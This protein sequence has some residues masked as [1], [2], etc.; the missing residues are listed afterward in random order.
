MAGK[1]N[2]PHPSRGR[3][4]YNQRLAARGLRPHDVVMDDLEELR[5]P[6]R[7]ALQESSQT[8]EEAIVAGRWP[9]FY[10]TVTPSG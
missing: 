4:H 6:H 2:K 10:R 8:T 3:S 5:K 9:E 7:V 1:Y